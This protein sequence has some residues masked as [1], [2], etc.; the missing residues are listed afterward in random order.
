MTVDEV[1]FASLDR[2]RGSNTAFV[3]RSEDLRQAAT[4]RRVEPPLTDIGEG[5]SN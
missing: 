5:I 1:T 3:K 2:E 4:D